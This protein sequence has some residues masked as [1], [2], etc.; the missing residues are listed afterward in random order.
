MRGENNLPHCGISP[1]RSAFMPATFLLLVLAGGCGQDGSWWPSSKPKNARMDMSSP[2]QMMATEKSPMAIDAAVN[3]TKQ[4]LPQAMAQLQDLVKA[5]QAQALGFSS[6]EQAQAATPGEPLAV[7]HIRLDDLRNYDGGDP[8]RLL[9]ASS[10]ATLVPLR[11]DGKTLSAIRFAR[12]KDGAY[13]PIAFG[14]DGISKLVFA[15]DQ[16]QPGEYAVFVRALGVAFSA[17]G[18]GVNAR[19]MPLVDYPEH[20]FTAGK[21]LPATEALKRLVEPARRANALPA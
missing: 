21:E 18:T 10:P 13:Q 4:A 12:G 8:S 1:L 6:S 16:Q 17:V 3:A 20:G 5:G 9:Q 15:R 7:A 19:F 2:P 14:H 11:A